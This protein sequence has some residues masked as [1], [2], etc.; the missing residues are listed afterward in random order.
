MTLR[1]KELDPFQWRIR[2]GLLLVLG[3]V[4]ILAIYDKTGLPCS[5][6]TNARHGRTVPSDG[7][8]TVHPIALKIVRKFSA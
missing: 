5:L 6:T 4:L 2:P 1:D 8:W 7:A 3:S